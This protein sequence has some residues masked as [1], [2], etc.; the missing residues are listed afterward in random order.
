MR[1]ATCSSLRLPCRGCRSQR[2]TGV[3]SRT[4]SGT[5]PLQSDL[6]GRKQRTVG[7]SVTRP[8]RPGGLLLP[9]VVRAESH[10][11]APQPRVAEGHDDRVTCPH[12]D[13]PP[14]PESRRLVRDACRSMPGYDVDC[15]RKQSIGVGIVGSLV[16]KRGGEQ[17]PERRDDGWRVSQ[18][19]PWPVPDRWSGLVSSRMLSPISKMA[20][21]VSNQAQTFWN[22][23]V[24]Q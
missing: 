20:S 21:G 5:Y 17:D 24:F 22:V 15:R 23:G 12:V 18:S 10:T 6:W 2:A 3:N 16:S 7:G 13:R 19:S 8:A 4:T 1:L 11:D 9:C 14:G